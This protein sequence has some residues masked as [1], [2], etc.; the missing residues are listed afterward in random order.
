MLGG[1]RCHTQRAL[2]RVHPLGANRAAVVL[3]ELGHTEVAQEVA[4]IHLMELLAHER[5]TVARRA[6]GPAAVERADAP[7][8]QDAC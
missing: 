6:A 3:R 7:A 1:A 5:S 8:K 2:A 4:R